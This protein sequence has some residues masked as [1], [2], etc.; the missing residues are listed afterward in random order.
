MIY[1]AADPSP[2]CTMSFVIDILAQSKAKNQPSEGFCE[3]FFQVYF[4][5]NIYSILIT[6]I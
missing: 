6:V 4:L 5:I 1:F 2:E 3:T